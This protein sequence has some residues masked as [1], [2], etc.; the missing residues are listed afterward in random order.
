MRLAIISDVH[1]NL[2]ALEGVIADIQNT[3]PDLVLQ[4][5]DLVVGGPRPGEVVDRSRQRGW[6]GAVG[7]TDEVLWTP[8]KFEERVQR[9]PKLRALLD[10]L[11]HDFSA[12]CDLLGDER[13]HWLRFHRFGKNASSPWCTPAPATFGRPQCPSAKISNSFPHTEISGLPLWST[14]SSIGRTSGR[15]PG[16]RLRTAAVWACRMTAIRVLAMLL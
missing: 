13:I 11:F 15:L 2:T 12:T 9:A 7:N 1:G 14:D 3:S 4:G 5:G 16:L 8:E 6:A 10:I